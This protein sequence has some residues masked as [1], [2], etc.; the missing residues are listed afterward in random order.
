MI[1]GSSRSKG[2]AAPFVLT[3]AMTSHCGHVRKQNED[4]VAYTL[5]ADSDGTP[6][7]RLLALV[8]DGIGG[9]LAGEVASRIAADTVLR[10]DVELKGSPPGVLHACMMADNSA[11]LVH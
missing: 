6:D 3:A 4:V 8:A 10:L 7:H 9:A 5:S 2:G 11:L 1:P